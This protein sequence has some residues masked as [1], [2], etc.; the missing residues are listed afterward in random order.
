MSRAVLPAAAKYYLVGLLLLLPLAWLAIRLLVGPAWQEAEPPSLVTVEKKS[1]TLD[2][3]ERGVVSP[4]RIAPISS[5]ISSNQAKI[6]WL[7]KEGTLV[8]KGLLVARFD[9]K[10]FMDSLLKAE[11]AFADAQAALQ[12][13]EKVLL[14][15]QEEEAGKIGDAERRLEIARIQAD[16]TRN[17]A[18]P[19]KRL[20]LEQ[21]LFQERRNLAIHRGDLADLADLLAKGHVSLRERDKAQDRVDTAA[22]QVAVAE[23]ELDNFNIYGWPKMLREAE[24]L[25]TGAESDLLRVRRSAELLLENRAAEVEKNRR[26]VEHRWR[27]LERAR[28]DVA[29]CDIYSP[30]DGLLLY[31]ELPRDSGRRKVQIGDS[32]WVGQTFLQV[33]D[34]TELVAELQI[35]EI[36]VAKVAP[37]MR[38]QLE[39]DAFPGQVFAGEV[40][41]VASLAREEGDGRR[42]FPARIRFLGDT[43][44]IHVGMSVTAKIVYA[45]L[46]EVPA[47]PISSVVYRQGQT[48][49]WVREGEKEIE[50]PVKLGARGR[51]WVEVQEGLAAGSMVLREAR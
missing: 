17:G 5:Q 8:R 47:I 43:G 36:D 22:E 3:L 28:I 19:L 4:A 13:A 14:L 34:T 42:R 25:A 51:L 46:V 30:N 39:V 11:Q 2:V 9:T 20:T 40:E 26:T 16:N 10:P 21:K 35:R 27:D 23:A 24:L 6:V 32:V 31:P 29:S 44:R 41:S 18:G 33:P 37:G 15:Q 50:V 7:L 45:E 38:V 49:V 1:F 48:F 12:V